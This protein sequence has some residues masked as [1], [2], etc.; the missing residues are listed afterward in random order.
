M[1]S[2]VER[3]RVRCD[4]IC[5][6]LEERW[7]KSA[8]RLRTAGTWNTGWPFRRTFVALKW[9]QAA[10]DMESAANGIAAIRKVIASGATAK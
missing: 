1:T 6:D 5:A 4:A 8:Q 2:D 9:E 7:R 10:K 3:E